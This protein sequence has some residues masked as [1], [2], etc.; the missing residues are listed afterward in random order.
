VLDNKFV[1]CEDARLFHY[2]PDFFKSKMDQ[3]H[4]DARIHKSEDMKL[5]KARK[6]SG[7]IWGLNG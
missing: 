6:E 7:I 4:K 5:I 2:H 1:Q 3:T